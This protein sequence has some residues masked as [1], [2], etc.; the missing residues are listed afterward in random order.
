MLSRLVQ[1]TVTKLM[2]ILPTTSGC[3]RIAAD[4]ALI[5]DYGA[6]GRNGGREKGSFPCV[7]VS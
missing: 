6:T 7:P 2:G 5:D 4:A 1:M 3:L